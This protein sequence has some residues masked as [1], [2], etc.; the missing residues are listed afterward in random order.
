MNAVAQLFEPGPLLDQGERKYLL[1]AHAA[2]GFW[3]IACDRLRP[4]IDV[5][6]R[7]VAYSRTTYFDTPDLA[8]F[9]S[10]RSAVAQRLRV[11][12]YAHA[13]SLDEVP[14]VGGRCFVELKQSSGGLRSKTRLECAPH[15]VPGRLAELTDE[16]RLEP[17]VATWYRRRALSDDAGTLRVTLDDRLMLCRPCSL[18]SEFELAPDQIVGHGPAFILE[19]KTFDGPPP[20]WLRHA[21]VGLDEA[22]GF[23]KFM[24]GMRAIEGAAVP[25]TAVMPAVQRAA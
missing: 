2:A 6:D 4:Q 25:M 22:V 5:K 21:L 9:R 11:R 15:E 3:A 10:G 20:A 19:V 24:L 17:C 12:E 18:G 7:P 8:Y 23:S 14:V 16:R 13:A 1:D